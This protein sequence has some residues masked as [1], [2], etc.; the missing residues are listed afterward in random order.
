MPFTRADLIAAAERSPQAATT[1]DRDGWV[2]LFAAG[3]QVEDPVGS[4]PHRGT[5]RIARFYDTFIGPR[6]I[7][8]H[9]DVDIVEATTVIRDLELEVAM[10]PS[11][12]MRI[13]AYLRYALQPAG[14]DLQITQLQAYW[15]LPAMVR[16]FLRSG[17]AAGPAGLHLAGALLRNQG[18]AGAL[19]FARGFRRAGRRGRGR[20]TRLLDALCAGDE[21]AVRRQVS[22]DTEVRRGDAE[23]LSTSELLAL[24]AGTRW[25]KPITSGYSLVAGFRG[26]RHRGVLIADLTPGAPTVRRLR[27]F[28]G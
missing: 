12:T 18:P 19:G 21:V 28:A 23:P 24:T 3:G 10:G 2:G 7:T 11:V 22:R 20:F 4:L 27:Y 9:R 16:Q 8:F 26:D 17:P 25:R 6:D 1:H 5:D 13:P 14:P 15:E